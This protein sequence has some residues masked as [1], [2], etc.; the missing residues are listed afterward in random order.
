[1]IHF[2]V[3]DCITLDRLQAADVFPQHG[4]GFRAGCSKAAKHAQGPHIWNQCRH[5]TANSGSTWIRVL[6]VL[7]EGRGTSEVAACNICVGVERTVNVTLAYK[8]CL[9]TAV[10][11]L[12]QL[13]PLELVHWKSSFSA[14]N[15][16]VCG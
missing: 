11:L 10:C 15:T 9:Q 3:P 5:L 4:G 7:K 14:W 16:A 8:V 2:Q 12:S 13:L 1:M 6:Q